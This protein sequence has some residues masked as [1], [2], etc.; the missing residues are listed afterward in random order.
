MFEQCTE[1]FILNRMK[2]NIDNGI[3][4]KEGTYTHDVLSPSANEVA[5]IYSQL[6]Y[7]IKQAFLADASGDYLTKKCK[8]F[9]VTRKDKQK[10]VGTVTFY[11]TE[12][13]IIPNHTIVST[14]DNLQFET[15]QTYNIEA[16]QTTVNVVVQA[17]N[18]GPSYNVSAYAIK[19]LNTSVTGITKVENAAAFVGGDNTESDEDLR[20]RA[21]EHIS[22]PVASGNAN[23]YKQW[24]YE[25][26]GVG[27]VKIIPT[28]NGP[29][30]VK[31][32]ILDS[33]RGIANDALI[34]TVADYIEENRPIGA[35]VTVTTAKISQITIMVDINQ[36]NSVLWAEVNAEMVSKINTYLT[37][38][39]FEKEKVSYNKIVSILEG[40]VSEGMIDDYRNVRINNLDVGADFN[41]ASDEIPVLQGVSVNDYN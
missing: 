5:R 12:G 33:N 17:M 40:L 11:G 35:T 23:H 16:G 39:A 26:N 8:E 9:N 18:Y 7:S 10:A 28:W 32:I 13:S 2:Q 38:I 27:A 1:S 29:G 30:S 24:A 41:L 20:E 34:T 6:D 3:D 25:C 37:D 4:T 14:V 19:K 31:V 22:E 21:F 15:L 36:N